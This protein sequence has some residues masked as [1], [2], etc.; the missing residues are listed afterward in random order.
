MSINDVVLA[1]AGEFLD[2]G[3]VLDNRQN[4]EKAISLY[5]N[6]LE[7]EPQ[8][9]VALHNTGFAH[10]LLGNH[11]KALQFLKKVIDLNSEHLEAHN[12]L[13]QVLNWLRKYNEAIPV[14]IKGIALEP[15]GHIAYLNFIELGYSYNQLGRYDNAIEV[16]SKAIEINPF[17]ASA[18]GCIGDSYRLKGDNENAYSS[19]ESAL[20]HFRIE[21]VKDRALYLW[22]IR[23][24]RGLVKLGV[25]TEGPIEKEAIAGGILTK[26]KITNYFQADR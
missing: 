10:S 23:A 24:E 1:R 15:E 17:C 6:V 11:E 20:S 2:A 21:S 19:Y 8:N 5:Q 18:E 14:I 26:K 25:K 7:D 3:T 13:G 9:T 12:V 16:L 22:A 4:L